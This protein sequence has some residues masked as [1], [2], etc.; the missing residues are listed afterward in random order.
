MLSSPD[1]TSD[2][3]SPRSSPTRVNN[4][5]LHL[6]SLSPSQATHTIQEGNADS[7]FNVPDTPDKHSQRRVCL[8]QSF[9]RQLIAFL[10][11]IGRLDNRLLRHS[12][13]PPQSK[14]VGVK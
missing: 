2:E 4:A 6:P 8:W 9:S 14:K 12:H 7:D 5:N 1:P 10:D 11:P 13:L 3:E